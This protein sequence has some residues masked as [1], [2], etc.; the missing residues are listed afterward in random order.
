MTTTTTTTSRT[1]DGV[2]LPAPGV[3]ELDPS[4]TTVGFWARHLGIAKVRGEFRTFEGRVV[5]AD[6]P[7]LSS[8]SVT[9]DAA[10]VDTGDP[11][12]DDHLRSADFLDV[13]HHPTMTFTST[14]VRRQGAAWEVDGDLTIRDVTRPVTLDAELLGVVTDEDGETKA[15]LTATAGFERADFGLTWNQVLEGSRLLVGKHVAIT[16]EVQL[17]HLTA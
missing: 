1:V 17:R 9:I 16:L 2:E 6:Q 8:V 12:R 15:V 3:W 14:A 13:E 5:V 11:N 10:S 4:H 7:E